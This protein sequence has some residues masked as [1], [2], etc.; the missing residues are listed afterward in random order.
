[1][2]DDRGA[3]AMQCVLTLDELRQLDTWLHQHIED[4]AAAIPVPAGRAVVEQRRTP[5]TTYRLELVT[6]GKPACRT[7]KA[8]P[9]HGPYW[10]A[11][12]RTGRTLRS[13]YVG[14]TRPD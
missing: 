3:L 12:Q 9:A 7:C 14:K 2:V 5:T 4:L 6:C 10:Y 1:M 11:Y 13:T 8:G